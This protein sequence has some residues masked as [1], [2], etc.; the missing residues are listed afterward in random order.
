MRIRKALG[1]ALV[2]LSVTTG[3]IAIGAG[4][5]QAAPA[6]ATAPTVLA[7]QFCKGS[8]VGKVVT[9]DNGKTVICKEQGGHNRWVIK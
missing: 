3:S 4:H 1:A 5:V 8:D 6:A 7:G 9:A 2:A